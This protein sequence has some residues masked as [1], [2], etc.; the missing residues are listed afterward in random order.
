MTTP[1]PWSMKN[2]GPIVAAGVDVDAGLRVRPLGD[3]AGDQRHPQ[4]VQRVGDAVRRHRAQPRVAEDDLVQAGGG[5]VA[6]IRRLHVLGEQF[7]QERQ[8]V[9]ERERD[10]LALRL[11]V[12]RLGAGLGGGVLLARLADEVVPQ[13]AGDLLG[14]AVVEAVD[15]RPDVEPHVPHVQ[16]LPPPVAG[17]QDPLEVPGDLAGPRR[18]WAAGSARGGARR[19]GRDSWRRSGRPVPAGPPSIESRRPSGAGDWRG[20][21]RGGR[22]V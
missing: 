3:H 4:P 11:E 22:S 1:V 17:E 12:V 7:P 9:Q 18:C 6:L 13:R 16:V 5:G 15:L 20:G 14:E 8:F 21:A 19:R 10:P 2:P